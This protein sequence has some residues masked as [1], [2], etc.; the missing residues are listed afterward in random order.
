MNYIVGVATRVNHQILYVRA[1]SISNGKSDIKI[2]DEIR[3]TYDSV[4]KI[5]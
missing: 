3:V 1:A 4:I 5:T 2:D